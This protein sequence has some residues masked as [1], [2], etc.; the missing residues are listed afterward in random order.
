MGVAVEASGKAT[1]DIIRILYGY[2]PENRQVVGFYVLESKETPGLG[3]K[4]EKDPISGK[5]QRAGCLLVQAMEKVPLK[6]S[7]SP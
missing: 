3:D 2:D 5:F 6:T 7:P 4:I 1:P